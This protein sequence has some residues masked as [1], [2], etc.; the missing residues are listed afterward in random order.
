MI[1]LPYVGGDHQ[2]KGDRGAVAYACGTWLYWANTLVGDARSRARWL[3]RDPGVRHIQR[4]LF[5]VAG[6]VWAGHS[7]VQIA[8]AS[9]LRRAARARAHMLRHPPAGFVIPR[10]RRAAILLFEA[11]AGIMLARHS[12]TSLGQPDVVDPVLLTYLDAAA[13][14]LFVLAL[15]ANER[16]ECPPQNR[17]TEGGPTRP[18]G[19]ARAD[20]W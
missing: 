12:L 16:V 15:A 14:Y 18:A 1:P 17:R 5:R 19:C 2:A 9:Q 13:E 6:S 20:A 3:R 7:L 8:W 4:T 10:G 11:S